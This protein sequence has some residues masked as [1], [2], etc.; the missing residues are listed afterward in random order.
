[1]KRYTLIV[2]SSFNKGDNWDSV[3]YTRLSLIDRKKKPYKKSSGSLSQQIDGMDFPN[4]RA[5]ST[6]STHRTNRLE[7]ATPR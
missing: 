5:H 7:R 6:P 1:M 4:A 2:V 3:P